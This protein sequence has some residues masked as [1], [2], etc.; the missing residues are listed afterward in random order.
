M[1][2]TVMIK[3]INIY[4]V[5]KKHLAHSKHSINIS[6][7]ATAMVPDGPGMPLAGPVIGTKA[8]GVHLGGRANAL[9][10]L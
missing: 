9:F 3:S 2:V 10:L 4:K 7:Y 6:Y 1:G 5:A 8:V